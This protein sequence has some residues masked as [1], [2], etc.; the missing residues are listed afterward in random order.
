MLPTGTLPGERRNRDRVL[1]VTGKIW[2]ISNMERRQRILLNPSIQL[3]L[4][5]MSLHPE[6]GEA[7][8]TRERG[9]QGGA[10]RSYS[11]AHAAL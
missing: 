7:R 2:V 9:V 4:G 8:G 6:T 3:I 5:D 11:P 1:M 10:H